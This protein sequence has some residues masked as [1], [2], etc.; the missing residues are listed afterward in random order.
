CPRAR[1]HRPQPDAWYSVTTGPCLGIEAPGDRRVGD[2]ANCDA[3]R[4][5]PH[6]DR[7]LLRDA[8][9]LVEGARGDVAEL[10]VDLVLLPEVLLEALD[11]L[12]VRHDDAAGIR[13]DVGQ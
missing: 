9:G 12:E 3:V 8:P 7:S 1:S 10:R 13:E 2:A 6:A 11:P 4:R 5:E